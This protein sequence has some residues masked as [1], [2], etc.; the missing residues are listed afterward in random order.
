MLQKNDII[1]LL[2]K[3]GI[4]STIGISIKLGLQAQKQKITICRVILSFVIGCGSSYLVYPMIN[5]IASD[6]MVA[7]II[8]M[9]AISSEKIAE[10]FI[11][12]WNIDYFLGSILEAFRQV[13]VNLI[14]KK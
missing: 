3:I 1:D 9:F 4:P 13:L 6:D 12:K 7:L 14:S 8:A 10:Y 11:Y 5:K 2:V